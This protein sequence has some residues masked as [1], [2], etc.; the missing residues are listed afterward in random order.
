MQ[1]VCCLST[2]V[3]YPE[4]MKMKAYIVRIWREERCRFRGHVSNPLTQARVTFR[5]WNELRQILAAD[6]PPADGAEPDDLSG[7]D[8]YKQ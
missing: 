6:C 1:F 2:A 8:G 4:R 7:A 5:D 3:C